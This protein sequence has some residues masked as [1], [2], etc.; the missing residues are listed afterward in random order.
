MRQLR[1]RRPVLVGLNAVAVLVTALALTG[2]SGARSSSSAASPG[3]LP[4]APAQKQA[5]VARLGFGAAIEAAGRDVAPDMTTNP[6]ISAPANLI[7]GERDGQI[8]LTVTLS[9][10][11]PNPVSVHY[12]TAD[13][14]AIA[15]T[16]CPYDY[17][18]VSGTLNFA[19]GETIKTVPVQI[20][21]ARTPRAVRVLHVRSH[22][23]G[24]RRDCE[25][26]SRISIVDDDHVV[27]Y[28]E[29]VRARCGR[30]R[31]GWKRARLGLLGGPAGQAS[32]STVTVH[33]ATA[34]RNCNSRALTTRSSSGT[35]TSRPGETAKTIAVRSWTTP[36]R[37]DRRG[38]S[39][40]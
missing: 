36:T 9:D 15:S 28:P 32:N 19:P 1:V 34:E 26:G 5:D 17:I 39:S 14:T 8:L 37:R 10:Q 29:A 16:G 38:S 20:S 25:G 11:S 18:G 27:A 3:T 40:T 4:A 21:T 33:Y 35:F 22:C 30:R 7:V 24:Q 13:S 6:A 2:A 23:G 12:A 31:E